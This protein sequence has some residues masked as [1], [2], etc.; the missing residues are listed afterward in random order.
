MSIPCI[1][2]DKNIIDTPSSKPEVP[3]AKN[4]KL[5]GNDAQIFAGYG[6]YNILT[7]LD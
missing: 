3:W 2:I 7:S 6:A 1:I 4:F 5:V